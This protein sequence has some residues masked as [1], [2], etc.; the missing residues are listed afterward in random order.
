MK[1]PKTRAAD[2]NYKSENEKFY[3]F[4]EIE[5]A[6]GANTNDLF[7]LNSSKNDCWFRYYII[8]LT[9]AESRTFDELLT[10][11]TPIDILQNKY[12]RIFFVL[13]KF[14]GNLPEINFPHTIQSIE[15]FKVVIFDTQFLYKDYLNIMKFLTADFLRQE[16]YSSNLSCPWLLAK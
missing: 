1:I 15:N 4:A 6:Y 10:Y 3:H 5:Q 7:I 9:G 11:N 12:R 2:Y 8:F 16:I 13:E 14:N